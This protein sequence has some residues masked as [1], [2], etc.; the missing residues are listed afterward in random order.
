MDYRGDAGG[1]GFAPGSQPSSGGRTSTRRNYDEQTVVPVTVAMMLQSQVVDE[2][3]Q[4]ADGRVLH[5]VRFVAAVRSYEDMSTNIEFEVEDGT[6]LIKVKEWLDDHKENPKTME[7]REQTKKEHVYIKVTGQLKDCS[8]NKQVVADAIR[9]LKTG[10]ELA[11]HMLEVVYMEQQYRQKQQQPAFTPGFGQPAVGRPLQATS[12]SE[13]DNLRNKVFEMVQMDQSDSGLNVDACVK[14]LHSFPEENVRRMF[15]T[16]SQE[17]VIYST[18]DENHFQWGE[19]YEFDSLDWHILS[20][21]WQRHEHVVSFVV[22]F[23]T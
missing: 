1:G 7:I 15:D 20:K 6:G 17:G 10:N 23:I 4:L 5:R 14:M 3:P 21:V 11:H 12:N 8:G 13:S 19:R 2:R 22:K 9:P 18:V 16:L